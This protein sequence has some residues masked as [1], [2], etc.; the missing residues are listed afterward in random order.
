MLLKALYV[1]AV[2]ERGA[3]LISKGHLVPVEPKRRVLILGVKFNSFL[4]LV[5]LQQ[6]EGTTVDKRV[7]FKILK[8]SAFAD[9]AILFID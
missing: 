6:S 3:R 7:W 9:D 5:G 4:V 2:E 8:V 1:D